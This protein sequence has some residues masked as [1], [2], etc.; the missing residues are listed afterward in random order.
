M[1][2]NTIDITFTGYDN[3]WIV[4]CTKNEINSGTMVTEY[5]PKTKCTMKK[6]LKD[7]SAHYYL[8]IKAL[9][10]IQE[11][12]RENIRQ[13]LSNGT[14]F[15]NW[16][17]FDYYRGK[18]K[19]ENNKIKKKSADKCADN[20]KLYNENL[21][22]NFVGAVQTKIKNFEIDKDKYDFNVTIEIKSRF[23]NDDKAY[24]LSTMLLAKDRIIPLSDS[25]PKSSDDFFDFLAMFYFKYALEKAYKSGLYR[26][27]QKFEENNDKP[28]GSI[29]VARH[30]KTQRRQK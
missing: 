2:S 25:A 7:K 26:T 17:E 28:K 13:N 16:N 24:F 23:D 15:I 1:S 21:Y 6:S 12:A 27:Y 10:K 19:P 14:I 22:G 4:N 3:S 20:F 8:L 9:N 29:D 11:D 18:L 30:I 5:N